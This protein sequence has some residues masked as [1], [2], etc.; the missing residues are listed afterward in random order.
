MKRFL[1]VVTLLVMIVS[2]SAYADY[3]KE[4]TFRGL[5]M[6]SSIQAVK[7]K[8]MEDG[9]DP[10]EFSI[11]EN[12]GMDNF[13]SSSYEEKFKHV[14]TEDGGYSFSIYSVPKD[15]KVAGYDVAYIWM[16]FMYKVVDGIPIK[17]MELAGLTKA[18]YIIEVVDELAVYSDIKEKL[19]KLYGTPVERKDDDETDMAIWYGTNDTVVYCQWDDDEVRIYYGT[20][21]T[22]ETIKTLINYEKQLAYEAEQK[23]IEESVDD[24]TGL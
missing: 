1:V 22:Y 5:P 12:E 3:D 19:T 4:I 6:G 18:R 16:D 17:D 7:D 10:S 20:T 21:S 8:L 15:F 24:T 11:D 23:L 9:I 13:F 14:I 2:L